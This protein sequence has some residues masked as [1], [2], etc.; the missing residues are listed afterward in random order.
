MTDEAHMPETELDN[1][2]CYET[3]IA[4]ES[5]DFDWPDARRATLPSALC[6]TSGTTGDPKG[7]LYESPLDGTACLCDPSHRMSWDLSEPVTTV[8]P[9]VPLF[10]VNAWGSSLLGR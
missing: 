5:D 10:H 8:L 7:V 1:V 6:Y 9:V 4:A 2:M 3:L